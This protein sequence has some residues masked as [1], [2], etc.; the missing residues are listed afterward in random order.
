MEWK[1]LPWDLLTGIPEEFAG[2]KTDEKCALSRKQDPRSSLHPKTLRGR[3][4]LEAARKAQLH[5]FT[6]SEAT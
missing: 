4:Q 5:R 1:R 3:L 6:S 2:W